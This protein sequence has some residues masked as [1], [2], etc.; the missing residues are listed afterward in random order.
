MQQRHFPQIEDTELLSLAE[1]PAAVPHGDLI[2]YTLRRG[3]GYGSKPTARIVQ[4][5]WPLGPGHPRVILVEFAQDDRVW[6]IAERREALMHPIRYDQ[7]VRNVVAAASATVV[8]PG[9]GVVTVCSHS[10]SSRFELSLPDQGDM[11]LIRTAHCDDDAPAVVAGEL[12][13]AAVEYNLRLNWTP[14]R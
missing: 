6:R 1:L 10:D 2:R 13:E 3:F 9:R 12:L 11:S 7:F 14:E 5:Q 4:V 8:G